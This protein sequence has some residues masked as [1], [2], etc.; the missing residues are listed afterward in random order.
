MGDTN[1]KYIYWTAAEK[2]GLRHVH[3]FSE[4]RSYFMKYQDMAFSDKT[5]VDHQA[6]SSRRILSISF[7]D[8]NV[9]EPVIYVHSK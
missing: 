1:V 6:S 7:D 9:G 5:K 3:S 4:L 2:L 8:N